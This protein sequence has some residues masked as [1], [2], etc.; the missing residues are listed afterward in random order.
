MKRSPISR[1]KPLSGILRTAKLPAK[2]KPAKRMKSKQRAVTAAER[3]FWH[4]MAGLGCVACRIDGRENPFIS[5]HHIE[6]RTKPGCHALVLPLCAQ[7]H[8]QDDTD[9]LGRVAVHPNKARFEAL[10]GTQYELLADA[11][12]RLGIA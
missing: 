10:Y 3:T 6:G 8:Q 9:P 12:Q 1:I 2:A 5:I 11:K 7:H 4:D